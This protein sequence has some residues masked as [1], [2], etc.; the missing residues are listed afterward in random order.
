M[1]ELSIEGEK[2]KIN[3]EFTYRDRVYEGRA[4]EGLLFNIRAVQAIFD[5]ANSETAVK[6][7]YPDTKKWDPDRNVAEL[8]AALPAWRQKGILGFTV[9]LQ[10]GM[11]IVKT[12][13]AQPWINSAFRPDGGLKPAYMDRLNRLLA[14]ADRLG[15]VVM[16][17]LFYFGQDENL[18][19]ETAV[20]TGV[21]N[22][23][24]WLLESKY[25]NIIVEINNECDV[26]LYE[27]D[28]LTP[29][30]VH[31][32]IHRARETLKGR[33]S[34]IPVSTSYTP[35]NIPTREVMEESDL[36]LV[37]GNTLDAEGIERLVERIRSDRAYKSDPK[38]IVFNE[39][40][41][42]IRNLNAAF[43]SYTSWG[44]YDQGAND[45]KDGF[46]S[47]P[48]NWGISTATKEGL[49]NRVAEI[50]GS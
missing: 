27:H 48:V 37:H 22:A 32:L 49:F 5:D 29:A 10:G 40:S 43:E 12:E 39:D 4:V 24:S 18:E 21:D 20:V 38:P 50:T 17:G 31:E 41:T 34:S 33:S 42:D 16:I 44:Y 7:V 19:D 35:R 15:M 3:G 47:P 1:T 36:I 26:P 25:Q 46:Q 28:I 11:P 30:R 23:V 45:Y 2:F 14:A 9:N 6:W 13:R 8:I